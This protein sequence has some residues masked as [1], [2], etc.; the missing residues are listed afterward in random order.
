MNS[1]PRW[2][3]EMTDQLFK[4][5]L[6]LENREEC[7][8]FFEDVA[9]INEIQELSQRLEVARMLKEGFIYEDI[10]KKTGASSATISRVKK[11]LNYGAD[12]YQLVLEKLKKNK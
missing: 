9:T 2:R 6:L 3:N 5:I 1:Y 10:A 7:Y 11:C 4:A 8:R 12:G